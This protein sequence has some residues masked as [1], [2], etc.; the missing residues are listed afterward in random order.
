MSFEWEYGSLIRYNLLKDQLYSY[1]KEPTLTRIEENI[2]QT[3]GQNGLSVMSF[4]IPV[5]L[6]LYLHWKKTTKLNSLNLT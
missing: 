1:L 5:T 2:G 3:K 6:R 4:R